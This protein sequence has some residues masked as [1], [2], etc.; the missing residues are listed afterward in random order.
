MMIKNVLALGAG[1]MGSQPGFYYAMAGFNVTQFDI[2]EEALAACKAHH[3]GYV[4]GFRAAFPAFTDEDIDAG[5]AR[6]SYSTDLESA[7]KDI[8]F[9]TES[10]PEVLEIKQQVYADLNRY[11]PEHTIFATNT[12]T[13]PPSAI[14]PS[15]GRPERFLAVHYAM[16][17]WDSPIAEVMKHPGTDDEVFQQV[18]QFVQ[19]SN[20]VPIKLEIEQP[21]YIIN[22][23]L[24][25][26]LTAGL[27]L[28]VNGISSHQDVDRTWMLCGQG[29]RMGPIG[30]LDQV[31]FDVSRNV[32]R[33]LAAAEP[34]NPQHQKNIDYLEEH[35]INKGYTGAL[36]GR[37]FYS[38]PDPEYLE[39]GFLK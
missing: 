12:S 9:V 21:G 11:C 26:W 7:A 35:F 28:V 32:N 38:Y 13:M 18:V 5:L 1:A 33:M 20:L 34:N 17:M 23:L 25:P 30:V 8:D 14:A 22:T 2:S 29:M 36:S 24:V 31:G 16:G 27:S 6:I 37:G 3:R 15:T 19:A 4:E 10:V 39:P